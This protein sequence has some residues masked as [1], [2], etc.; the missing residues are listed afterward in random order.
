ME[1]GESRPA[2]DAVAWLALAL[3]RGLAPGR[4]LAFIRENG[5]PDALLRATPA[6][7][8][9]AGLGAQAEEIA[10]VWPRAEA[11]AQA[12]GMA[13]ARLVTWASADY[14]ER[15]R[16]IADP[17]LA[18]AVRGALAAAEPAVAV[19]GARRAT[20]YG[21]RMAEE[22]AAGLARA[23]VAVVS[24]LATGIDAAAHRAALGA[25][26]RTVAVLGTGIDRVYPP[27]HRGLAADVARGGALVSEFRCGAPALQHHFPQRNR[28]ISGMSLGT[29]VVEAAERS[30]SL[31][32]A[33]LALEQ[34]R[35]VFAVPGPV[36]PPQHRAPHRLIQ[37]GAKLVTRAEDVLEEIAP[38]LVARLAAVQVALAEAGLEPTELRVLAAVGAGAAHV[39]QVIGESGLPPGKALETLLAL[40]LRGVVEQVPGK[41]FR[42]RAA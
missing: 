4:A 22:L 12:I 13:G 36:G 38:A 29:V 31:I 2:G 37:Q 1:I 16:Q 25:G 15:L 21:L 26:G 27:W 24:G 6:A 42:R 19:V 9:A 41:R 28:I 40:E 3:V 17:P 18:L 39:D 7:L 30:G 11:E 34:G 5:G 14:P 10:G 32:T 35:E 33:R 20:P 23:G 8:G